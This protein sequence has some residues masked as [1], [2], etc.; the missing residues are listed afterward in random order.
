[1]TVDKERFA[2]GRHLFCF[3]CGYTARR[4]AGRLL[5]AGARVSGTTR[6]AQGAA[7]LRTEGIVAHVFD[8]ATA[9]PSS[10]FDGVTDV[11]C[12]IPPGEGGED[13]VITEHGDVLA[14][15]SSLRW[16]ALLSTTGVYG[17]VAG[18]WID[19]DAPLQPMTERSRARVACEERWLAWG[20]TS[21]KAVQVFRLPGIYGPGRSPFARIRA[22]SA[23]RIIKADQVFNRI[24]VDDIGNALT[25]AMRKPEAG[26]VFHLADD[27]PAPADEVLAHAASL[28]G[29]PPPPAVPFD[30]SALS[31]MA[32][33]FYGECK[34]LSNRKARA[35]LGFVPQ[36]P[37]YREGLAAVLAEEGR[38]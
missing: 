11:L 14:A 28:L 37:T 7:E 8:G 26:P 25:L 17:D 15:L 2:A 19:E 18:A 6:T 29:L 9:V 16:V 30:A 32:R 21:G 34:R 36:Y 20:R 4:L 23:Q 1:M 12:S 35:Q 31:P 22:G 5:A 38:L 3:G 13:G 27:E 10:A 33:Q 24:H